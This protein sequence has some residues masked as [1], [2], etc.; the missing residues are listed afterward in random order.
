VGALYPYLELLT[1]MK[2]Y[3]LVL[4]AFVFIS[5]FLWVPDVYAQF[6]GGMGGGMGGAGG[7]H[8]GS[9]RAKGCENA[10]K[11]SGNKGPMGAQEPMSREQLEYHLGTLQA[12][13]HLTA[14]Q[15]GAWQFFA[16]RVLALEAD[17]A[18]QR[19]R[20]TS[21]TTATATATGA[22]KPIANAVD[23]ARNLLTALEDIE[24]AGKGLYLTLQ[25]DQKT[26]LDVRMGSFLPP[27]LRG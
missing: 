15:A 23:A 9:E 4:A 27:L 6:G 25:P 8:G 7:R 17:L 21:A 20:R 11:P 22:I 2:P 10:D 19:L 24:S 12:D 26:L 1:T 18:R 3:L 16:D 5:S 14:E 13:L